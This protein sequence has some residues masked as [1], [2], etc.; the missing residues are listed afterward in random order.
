MIENEFITNRVNSE[1]I[2]K[3]WIATKKAKMPCKPIILLYNSSCR[4]KFNRYFFPS[5]DL[6][7]AQSWTTLSTTSLM[8]FYLADL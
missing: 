4:L 6:D 1:G 5:V 8:A 2:P 7:S 3:A